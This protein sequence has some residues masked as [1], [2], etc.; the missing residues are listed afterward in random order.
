MEGEGRLMTDLAFARVRN[1]VG[2]CPDRVSMPLCHVNHRTNEIGEAVWTLEGKRVRHMRKKVNLW[3]FLLGTKDQFPSTSGRDMQ[4]RPH[5]AN[6]MRGY[7]TQHGWIL[8]PIWEA[9]MIT[10][11]TSGWDTG[12]LTEWLTESHQVPVMV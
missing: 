9:V 7:R 2:Q 4:D 1:V 11:R 5:N 8:S 12:M 3:L 6:S 10:E